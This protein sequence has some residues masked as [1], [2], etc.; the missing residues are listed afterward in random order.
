MSLGGRF[1]WFLAPSFL[2]AGISFV[3]IPIAT[4][5]LGPADYGSFALVMAFSSLGCAISCLGSSF[6]FA[7][8]HS[9]KQ[10]V[11]LM[12][13]IVTQQI[14]I[15]LSIAIALA[16][17]LMIFW[18]YL[19]QF[20]PSLQTIPK[21]GVNLVA[22]SM[23]PTTMWSLAADLMT[24]DGR[25]KLFAI[26]TMA[27]SVLSAGA[28]IGSLIWFHT[29]V[30]ALFFSN[31]IGAVILGIGA[32]I[33]FFRYLTWPDF[34]GAKTGVLSGA[35]T[36]TFAN[37]FEMIYPLIERNLLVANIG[38]AALGLHTHAQQYRTVVGVAI[39]ALARAIW[40]I[41]L[42]ESQERFLK[43][44]QTRA[45]WDTAYFVIG[46]VG[47][48]F[49]THG[50]VLIGLITHGKFAEAG[51]YAAAGIAYLLFQN[52]GKP[53]TGILYAKGQATVFAKYSMF[54][55][56]LGI[57]VATVAI[58]AMGVWGAILAAFTHQLFLRIA[59]QI[60]VSSKLKVPFQDHWAIAELLL[61]LFMLAIVWALDMSLTVRSILLFFILLIN[62]AVFI[63]VEHRL[64]SL[65]ISR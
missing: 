22:V 51:P 52:M 35:T 53:F 13:R 40:P 11:E 59:M 39:K 10:K 50:S 45:H 60:L 3:S 27:Q 21:L 47:I 58:P 38:V 49:A 65:E 62:T 44:N 26:T 43:F 29:D 46:I 20:L 61:I 18:P 16:V 30:S 56:L 48:I 63:C 2:Q 55:G 28:L 15:A 1:R 42:E 6:V 9:S 5:W 32:A 23:L 8:I 24:L 17:S 31:A 37:I 34:W 7:K 25:T 33:A 36:I 57:I 12:A 41:T 14:L 64:A 54:A 4:L 19:I